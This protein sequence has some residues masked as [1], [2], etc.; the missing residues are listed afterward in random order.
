MR[1]FRL[2]A[3]AHR[4]SLQAGHRVLV[5]IAFLLILPSKCTV[6][7]LERLMRFVNI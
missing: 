5:S 1:Q 2:A 4:N 6:V 3:S 7:I